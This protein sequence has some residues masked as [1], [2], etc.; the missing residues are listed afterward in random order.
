MVVGDDIEN[1]ISFGP[2]FPVKPREEIL[3][4]AGI[5]EPRKPGPGMVGNGS[6][7]PVSGSYG[8]YDLWGGLFD[9]GNADTA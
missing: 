6:L 4:Q 9:L 3:N 5:P 2:G 8:R 7:G 1:C